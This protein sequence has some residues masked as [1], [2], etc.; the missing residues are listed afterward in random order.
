MSPVRMYI[1]VGTTSGSLRGGFAQPRAEP[2]SLRSWI[3]SFKG[4]G[5]VDNDEFPLGIELID[6]FER[7]AP[8]E[9]TAARL[10]RSSD[11]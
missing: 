4:A 5:D 8:S 11:G 9:P 1:E 2:A 6:S 3:G 7:L 10:R